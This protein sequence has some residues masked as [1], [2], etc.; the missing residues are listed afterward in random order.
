MFKLKSQSQERNSLTIELVVVKAAV[1]ELTQ[2][3]WDD[4]MKVSSAMVSRSIVRC[5]LT[6]D[7]K[8]RSLDRSDSNEN[9]KDERMLMGLNRALLQISLM[10]V[11]YEQ[12]KRQSKEIELKA[13]CVGYEG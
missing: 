12:K 6:M 9:R 4:N 2:V 13:L 3:T 8:Y 10:E 5:I 7:I 1:T 11:L